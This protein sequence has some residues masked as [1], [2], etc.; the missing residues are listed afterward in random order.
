MPTCC[1]P[2]LSAV[3]PPQSAP[4]WRLPVLLP[5]LSMLLWPVAAAFGEELFTAEVEVADAG[6]EARAPGIVAAFAAVLTK[7][8]GRSDPESLPSWP[9]LSADAERL[10]VEY[11]YR[12]EAPASLAEDPLTP[13]RTLLTVRFE[14]QSLER[15]LR[16]ARLPIWGDTRPATLLLLAVERGTDR[17]IYTPDAMPEAGA[18]ISD[19]ASRRGIP[20]LE[21]LMDL[22]DRQ[23][24]RFNEVWGGFPEVIERTAARYGPDAVLVG[25]LFNEGER[26]WRAQ[27]TLRLGVETVTWQS[28]GSLETTL[29]GGLDQ[30]ADRLA[31][32]YVPDAGTAEQRVALAV[33]GIRDPA[34]YARVMAFL[35]GLTAVSQVQPRLASRDLLELE[36]VTEVDPDALLR[37]IGLGG[38]L[39]PTVVPGAPRDAIPRFRLRP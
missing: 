30:L 37:T 9:R 12:V 15:L 7:V 14:R 13:R 16:E 18:A 32:R 31:Q 26:A 11:R 4:T 5:L 21:P 39:V 27:W 36:L 6:P 1:L 23:T 33:T 29:A 24:L 28:Q 25:R 38:T 17:F 8:T 10:L 34:G 20:L 2:V 35:A 19:A 22:E 3:T